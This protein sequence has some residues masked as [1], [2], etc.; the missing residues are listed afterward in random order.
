MA[1]V[2]AVAM[3]R[4]RSVRSEKIPVMRQVDSQ[5]STHRRAMPMNHPN[6]SLRIHRSRTRYHGYN[7]QLLIRA[8]THVCAS[9]FLV[10]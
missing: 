1:I 2:H 7:R 3:Q 9:H 5:S 4:E 8:A 10:S 6:M